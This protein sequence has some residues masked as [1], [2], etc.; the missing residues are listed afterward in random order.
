[1]R[2]TAALCLLATVAVAGN[3][4]A[5]AEARMAVVPLQ[6]EVCSTRTGEADLQR[7]EAQVVDHRRRQDLERDLVFDEV[8]CLRWHTAGLR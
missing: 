3:L 1:M 4:F 7:P 5:G 8:A 6:P 2:K